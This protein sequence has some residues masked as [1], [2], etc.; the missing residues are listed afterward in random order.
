MT[1]MAST[2]LLS[3]QNPKAEALDGAPVVVKE[4]QVGRDNFTGMSFLEQDRVLQKGR[5]PP[6]V[7]PYTKH[8]PKAQATSCSCW[9]ESL[10]SAVLTMRLF[11]LRI[12][13][14]NALPDTVSDLGVE[15]RY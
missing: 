11:K 9:M 13:F 12:S 5:V 2:H 8:P 4:W 7:N 6:L 15:F 3:G 14:V 1:G 10:R